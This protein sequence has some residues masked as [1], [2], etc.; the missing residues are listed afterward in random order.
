MPDTS[1]R[2]QALANALLVKHQLPSNNMDVSNNAHR[3]K[4][5]RIAGK[6]DLDQLGE[7]LEERWTATGDKHYSL[8]ELADYVNTMILESAV[9]DSEEWP[10]SQ[11]IEHMY[12]VLQSENISPGRA[13]ELKRNLNR[14]GIDVEKVT[15]DFVSHQ[16]VHSYLKKHRK[17]NYT[18]EEN[19]LE[20]DLE[21][22]QRV[23]GRL[24]NITESIIDKYQAKNDL[25]TSDYSVFV[26]IQIYCEE[27]QEKMAL[28]DYFEEKGCDC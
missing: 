14:V 15:A 19:L 21:T 11:D 12:T 20:E 16:A 9:N 27:C 1:G 26:D 22:I 6:Y 23:R 10:N 8:R 13:K 28:E 4:I 7:K 2:Y 17:V 3:P 24:T 25:T 5:I 18:P